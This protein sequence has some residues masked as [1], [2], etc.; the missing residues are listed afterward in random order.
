MSFS[1]RSARVSASANHSKNPVGNALMN[2]VR[3]CK[4]S[5][6]PAA[7]NSPVSS[8]PMSL[9][10]CAA[11]LDL[12]FALGP[13]DTSPEIMC[14]RGAS[15][16]ASQGKRLCTFRERVRNVHW[17]ERGG[18]QFLLSARRIIFNMKASVKSLIF[19]THVWKKISQIT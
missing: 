1:N 16:R 17:D 13:F 11:A 4:T 15:E 19:L 18:R 3:N 8:N 2:L 5:D 6:R 10:A 9:S 12:T 7:L 14:E